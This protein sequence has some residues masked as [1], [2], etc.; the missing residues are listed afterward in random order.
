MGATEQSMEYC[1]IDVHRVDKHGKRY[2]WKRIH[3]SDLDHTI[4]L[5]VEAESRH[6]YSTVQR[7]YNSEPQEDELFVCPLY[8]DLDA[9]DD[10]NRARVDA[11]RLIDS[12]TKGF[13]LEDTTRLYFSGNRGFHITSDFNPEPSSYLHKVIRYMAEYFAEKA[14]LTTFDRSVYSK[15]RMW[16]VTNTQHGK[17]GL[18]K[19]PLHFH[20]LSLS[21][22]EI[23]ELAESPREDFDDGGDLWA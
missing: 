13:H 3:S 23:R 22:D 6:I 12:L 11:S 1:Y 18:W 19:I 8:F 21:C 16:R 20:E 17:S 10:L 5:M 15:R 4:K 7:F 2:K 9:D 14:E